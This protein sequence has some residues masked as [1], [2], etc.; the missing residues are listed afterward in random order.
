[1]TYQLTS[2]SLVAGDKFSGNLGRIG[3]EAIGT[4]RILQNTLT[5]GGNYNL[6]YVE[7]ILTIIDVPAPV[8][9]NE[10]SSVVTDTSITITWTTDFA[11]TSRVVYDTVPHS[12]LGS[13]PSYGYA[14][15]TSEDSNKVTNHSVIVSSL[16][17]GTT[18]YF[19][20]VSHASPQEGVS[21]EI[22]AQTNHQL[23]GIGVYKTSLNGTG[24]F[25]FTGVNN[26][27]DIITLTAGVPEENYLNVQ[28]GTYTITEQAQAGWTIN[29]PSSC[30]VTVEAGKD[31]TCYFINTYTPTPTTGTL[32][33]KKVISG[34]TLGYTA[35]S[36]KVNNG[37][38]MAFNSTGQNDLTE[39][40]GTYSVTEP[41]V[42]NYNTTYSNCSNVAIDANHLAATC[43]I[44]NTYVASTGKGKISGTKFNDKDGDGKK[45]NGEPGLA[46]WTI[47]LDLNNNSTLDAGEP[48]T[49]TASNGNYSFSN[50]ANGTYRV[51]E[52]VQ[53]G[54][55]QTAPSSGVN[56]VTIT[57]RNSNSTNNNFGN[58]K[59][60]VISGMKFNDLNGNGRKNSNEPGLAG[61]TI[62]LRKGN[63]VV[64]T[65]VTD[66]NGNYSF[67]NVG[68]GTYTVREVQQ[69]GWQQ[70]TS[71][72]SSITIH[73]GDSSTGNNFG[74]HKR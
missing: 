53:A 7:G 20:A 46:G 52:V 48:S 26:G 58:F 15:S 36:F 25:H 50:L 57:N 61:W 49:V 18:Y 3:G 70:T 74:N 11:A 8:I 45:E 30:T 42:A 9:S 63:S 23:S 69:N 66:A 39:N 38:A 54:W 37:N 72:P 24:T 71:N 16:I 22:S 60:G 43:T 56:T 31:K 17:P 13:E 14:Y 34:G 47:Y 41:A 62:Q 29:S 33:V 21:R 19:R 35:F 65:T 68:P 64:A 27:F 4:Y 32:T 6:T 12:N 59:Y 67:T 55:L 51:R 5:A 73:S 44:T 2:G 10:S 1:L 40:F 28:S